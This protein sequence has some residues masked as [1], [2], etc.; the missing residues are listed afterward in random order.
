MYVPLSVRQ[1]TL[2]TWVL[3]VL[4]T[5][6]RFLFYAHAV[7]ALWRW[8]EPDVIGPGRVRQSSVLNANLRMIS[9]ISKCS[10]LRRRLFTATSTNSRTS[11]G[12]MP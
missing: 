1:R 8:E 10:P 4:F 7:R 12:N 11:A 3:G 5:V 9:E 2:L 6:S